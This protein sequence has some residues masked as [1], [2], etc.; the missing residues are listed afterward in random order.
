VRR[1]VR[2][3]ARCRL[4]RFPV[5]TVGPS[6]LTRTLKAGGVYGSGSEPGRVEFYGGT[7]NNWG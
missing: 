5:G 1:F 2:K 3:V 6:Y 4:K 7:I